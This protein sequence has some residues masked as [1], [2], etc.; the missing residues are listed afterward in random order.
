MSLQYTCA[1][2]ASSPSALYAVRRFLPTWASAGSPAPCL[3][4]FAATRFAHTGRTPPLRIWKL[5]TALHVGSAAEKFVSAAKRFVV[6]DVEQDVQL[7][8]ARARTRSRC[9]ARSS[10][11][12]LF[13]SRSSSISTSREIFG[14]QQRLGG[15]HSAPLRRQYS[16][17]ASARAMA[18]PQLFALPSG[19]LVGSSAHL[20]GKIDVYKSSRQLSAADV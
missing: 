8:R 15:L 18:L 7:D 16:A 3:R 9:S 12:L 14:N 13:P 10:N 11:S 6:L 5:V 1:R 4:W 2:P 19:A 20:P 17:S